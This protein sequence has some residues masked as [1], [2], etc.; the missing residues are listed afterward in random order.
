VKVAGSMTKLAKV[1]ELAWRF[2]WGLGWAWEWV[3]GLRMVLVLVWTELL[4]LE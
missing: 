4:S 3:S 1:M 2:E